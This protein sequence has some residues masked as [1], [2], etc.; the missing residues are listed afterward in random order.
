MKKNVI[1]L[2]CCGILAFTW[3]FA[4]EKFDFSAFFKEQKG[5]SIQTIED[6]SEFMS[7][8]SSAKNGEKAN[9]DE[10]EASATRIKSVGFNRYLDNENLPEKISEKYKNATAYEELSM[11]YTIKSSVCTSGDSYFK[12]TSNSDIEIKAT[13][14]CI[15]YEDIF[16]A[17]IKC[18]MYVSNYDSIED[19]SSK[20][21]ESK[22]QSNMLTDV[23]FEAI[24]VTDGLYLKIKNEESV[25]TYLTNDDDPDCN[26]TSQD[27]KKYHGKWI[28]IAYKDIPGGEDYKNN[29]PGSTSYNNV[30][31]Y[32]YGYLINNPKYFDFSGGIYSL[33]RS[34]QRDFFREYYS[35]AFKELGT[36]NAMIDY[37]K[38]EGSLVLNLQNSKKPV[39]FNEIRLNDSESKQETSNGYGSKLYYSREYYYGGFSSATVVFQNINSTKFDIPDLTDVIN[40]QDILNS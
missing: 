29:M 4:F 28:Y 39:L 8:F 30:V 31:N 19:D 38:I 17:D 24:T 22:S 27:S 35:Y 9:S 16:Y 23:D 18:R 13:A 34:A 1:T 2:I 12:N 7:W 10:K 3:L 36:S 6:F 26:V 25:S 20:K 15:F 11:K 40:F 33:K 21:K 32:L 5:E 37:D 14:K